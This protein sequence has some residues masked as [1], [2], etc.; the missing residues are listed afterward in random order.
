MKMRGLFTII[1]IVLIVFSG[2]NSSKN[3]SFDTLKITKDE[4]NLILDYLDNK[5]NDIARSKNG[6][7]YSAFKLLGASQDKLYIWVSKV[8]YFKEGNE[9]TH[10]CGDA[11]STPVVLTFK[12]TDKSISIVRHEHPKDGESYNK[13]V[14]KLFP[15]NIK[16]PDDDE[17]SKLVQITKERAEENY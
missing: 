9:I 5:T 4:E 11:V 2:C 14:K 17:R 6:K 10:K 12:K 7:M 15:P 13:N 8:E 16:F 1:L 3:I